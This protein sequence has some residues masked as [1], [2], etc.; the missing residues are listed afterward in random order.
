MDRNNAEFPI[1]FISGHRAGLARMFAARV[2]SSAGMG[3]EDSLDLREYPSRPEV[4]V[5]R[6]ERNVR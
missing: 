2:S 5:S 3:A 6:R 4:I 1:A